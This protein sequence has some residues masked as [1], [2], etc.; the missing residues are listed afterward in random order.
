MVSC[1]SLI[2]FI[3]N[4]TGNRKTGEKDDKMDE[5]GKFVSVEV[6][7]VQQWD[8]GEI[9][10]LYREAGWWKEEWDPVHINRLIAGSFAFVVAVDP[11]SGR[12]V[13][14]GRAISDGISDA[15]IQDMIVR[16]ECRESGIGRKML[17]T[18]TDYCELRGITWIALIAE[19]GTEQF[20]APS[21]FTRMQ[22]YV[23]MI[24]QVPSGGVDSS[25]DRT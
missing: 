17:K 11:K 13:A 14:M 18:L 23:P 7:L 3:P 20:Y 10:S 16:K 9:R 19:P 24:Y 5:T 8:I 12:A 25:A 21:G 1:V 4:S 2:S 15:Y 6:R 22:G